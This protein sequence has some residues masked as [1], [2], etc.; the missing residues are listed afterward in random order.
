MLR[1]TLINTPLFVKPTEEHKPTWGLHVLLYESNSPASEVFSMKKEEHLVHAKGEE[2]EFLQGDGEFR[3]SKGRLSALFYKRLI[4]LAES[5]KV[6]DIFLY[7]DPRASTKWRAALSK[8]IDPFMVD[9][10]VCT[11]Q[12]HNSGITFPL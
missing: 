12:F 10:E 11:P 7:S 8:I 3:L 4:P 5:A 6:E 2:T 9:F 1:L